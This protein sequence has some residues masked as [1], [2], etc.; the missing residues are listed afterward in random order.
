MA[1]RMAS[2]TVSS[3]M[4]KPFNA[5]S[6]FGFLFF[7]AAAGMAAMA[8]TSTPKDNTQATDKNAASRAL[9]RREIVAS[10]VWLESFGSTSF[11]W[12]GFIRAPYKINPRYDG[13]LQTRVV[14]CRMRSFPKDLKMVL[15]R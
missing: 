10:E 6:C 14:L 7:A 11:A 9:G 15:N 3:V 1:W 2:S 4:G 8:G 5:G 13:K 12:L